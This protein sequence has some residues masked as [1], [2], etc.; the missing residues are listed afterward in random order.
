MDNLVIV[1]KPHKA[2][3]QLIRKVLYINQNRFKEKCCTWDIWLQ[4]CLSAHIS[5]N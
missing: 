3:Y 5:S 2:C 1:Q 4:E